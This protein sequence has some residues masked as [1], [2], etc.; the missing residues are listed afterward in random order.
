[1][2]EPKEFSFGGERCWRWGNTL[3]ANFTAGETRRFHNHQVTLLSVAHDQ[4]VA[5]V[6][7]QTA[8]LRMAR[9][10]VPTN[11]RGV[12][13]FVADTRVVASLTDDTFT[14]SR[15]I[16]GLLQGDALLGLCPAD[17]PLLDP[18]RYT[19]PIDRSEGFEWTMEE[20]SH[21]F[22]YLGPHRSHEGID[23]DLHDA[24]G[25]ARH[26][27]VAIED[28]TVVVTDPRRDGGLILQSTADPLVH[29][30]YRHLDGGDRFLVRQGQRVQKGQKLG[31][32]WGD[33]RW[34][35]LHFAVRL[36]KQTPTMDTRY[37]DLL[38]CFPQCYELWHGDLTPRRRVWPSGDWR[39]FSRNYWEIRNR[40]LLDA[41]DPLSGRGWDLDFGCAASRVEADGNR[42]E[43]PPPLMQGAR[44][45]QV[46]HAGTAAE[47]VNP[48]D[49]YV[50]R[51]CVPNGRYLVRVVVGDPALPTWQHV[52]FNGVDAGVF[53]LEAGRFC[54]SCEVQ[55]IVDDGELRCTFQQR[56]RET[57]SA[58]CELH[59]V[60]VG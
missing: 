31:Y 32:I 59:F 3:Y 14:K 48:T 41:F 29:Y 1:M 10:A 45:R 58:V 53:D 57:I 30:I 18:D 8:E 23:F 38:N 4:C 13:I 56:D 49:R 54:S 47:C 11:V 19:F 50:F 12:R 22:A 24:R 21:M 27:L 26:A 25:V 40:K 36:S 52:D 16:H 42:Q 60:R 28:A 15:H 20:D 44:L 51:V 17:Q 37:D 55:T 35:H 6:D 2:L 33:W 7:D 9:R 46:L 34:G 5:R 43:Q 39:F